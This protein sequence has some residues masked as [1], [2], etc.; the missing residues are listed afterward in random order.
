MCEF[1]ETLLSVFQSHLTILEY[2][3]RAVLVHTGLPGRKQIYSY[4]QDNQGVWWKILDHVVTEVCL[5]Y[6]I[7]VYLCT[8]TYI[9]LSGP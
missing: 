2:D 5:K 6:I 4:V 7:F 8:Y 3:L 1:H 9:V